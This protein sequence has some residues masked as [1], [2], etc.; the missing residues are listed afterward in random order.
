MIQNNSENPEVSL[1][2]QI[3]D[4]LVAG[5]FALSG[6]QVRAELHTG[7]LPPPEVVERYE[8]LMPSAFDRILTMAENSQQAMIEDNGNMITILG[9]SVRA[10]TLF[11]QCGQVFGFVTVIIFF[12]ILAYSM[13][14]GNERMFGVILGAGAL[15]GLVQLVRSYQN[16]GEK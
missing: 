10:G 2:N 11:A 3:S 1:P 14:L 8:R 12:A 9:H 16:K 7:P 15:V 13:Y 6:I 5:G 4:N